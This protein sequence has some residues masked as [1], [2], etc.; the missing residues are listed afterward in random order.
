MVRLAE[1][2]LGFD[3]G[4]LLVFQTDAGRSGYQGEKLADVYS[5]IREKIES[6]PGVVSVGLSQNSLIQGWQTGDDIL[7]LANSP[8]PGGRLQTFLLDCSDSFLSTVHIPLVLGRGL[9]PSDGP[10]SRLIT[11]VNETFVRSY[12]LPGVNPIGQ[13]LGDTGVE[14]V[15]V[16][17]DAH[18]DRVRGAP[19]PT[20]YF[21][22]RQKSKD[23][24]RM[25]YAIRTAVP[26]LSVAQ[27][28]Q[29]AVSEVDSS[30]PVYHLRTMEDQIGVSLSSEHIMAELVSA[31]GLAAA[32][33]AAIGLYGVMAYTVARRT[34]EI[35]IRM[36]LGANGRSV[37]WLV[38]RE[39]VGMIAA[40]LGIGV[41]AA[42]ALGRLFRSMLFGVAPNDPW[43]F[44]AAVLLL[45]AAGAAAAYFPARRASRVDPM[46]ALRND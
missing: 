28:V 21:P 26:P 35:G 27:S 16:V 3:T 43:S 42:L 20:A 22:Y 10:G 17:K 14:I 1:V 41:P 31:F 32:L 19:P 46:T 25:S 4:H 45:A 5:R 29:R 11:V 39:S 40:G 9:A 8:R 18:Y 2:D 33:L 12:F 24:G 23:L 37:A 34:S 7:M 36:A 6:V 30:I 15:G 13:K 44:I 38:V